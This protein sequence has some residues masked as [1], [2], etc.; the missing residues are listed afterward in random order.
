MK[1]TEIK[2][3][4]IKMR[5]RTMYLRIHTFFVKEYDFMRNKIRLYFAKRDADHFH[6]INGSRYHV[7]AFGKGY[8]AV[9]SSYI[10]EYNKIAK[11]KIDIYGLLKMSYYS[12]SVRPLTEK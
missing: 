11:K 1:K 5:L 2:C 4:I 3:M 8:K 10:H 12:T 6:K 9:D 7:V